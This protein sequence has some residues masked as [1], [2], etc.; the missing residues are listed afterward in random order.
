MSFGITTGDEEMKEEIK[1]LKERLKNKESSRKK[2]QVRIDDLEKRYAHIDQWGDKQQVRARKAE[3]RLEMI[4]SLFP[5]SYY[6][7]KYKCQAGQHLRE[8]EEFILDMH[9]HLVVN[10]LKDK[11]ENFKLISITI[12]AS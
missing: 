11:Y 8:F 4:D 3:D 12:G 9:P 7:I 10:G 6:H 2:L 5:K 1:K